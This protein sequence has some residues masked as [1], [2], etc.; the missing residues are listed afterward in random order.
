MVIEWLQFRVQEELREQFVQLDAEIWTAAL[1]EYSGF[2]GKEVWISPENLDEVITVIRWDSTESWYSI[3]SAD[4]AA[5]DDAFS[6]AM[7]H[8]TYTLIASTQYQVRKFCS[9]DH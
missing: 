2:L 9:S 3:P 6:E 7:G 4:L 8:G 5:I 1:A